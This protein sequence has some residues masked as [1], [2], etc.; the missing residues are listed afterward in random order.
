MLG[1]MQLLVALVIPCSLA[2]G[3]HCAPINWYQQLECVQVIRP[4]VLRSKLNLAA[5][6]M[7]QR[8]ALRTHTIVK[9]QYTKQE[10][11]HTEL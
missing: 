3:Q 8:R 1:T 4:C 11:V 10:K 6:R 2:L 9:S 5:A 7:P